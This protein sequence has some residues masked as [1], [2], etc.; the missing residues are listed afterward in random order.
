MKEEWKPIKESCGRYIVSNKGRVASSYN[1]GKCSKDRDDDVPE[2]F[3]L[4]KQK[5]ENTGYCRVSLFIDGKRHMRSVHRLVMEAF[6]G[7]SPKEINH[8]N[9]NKQDNRVTN[10]EYS[11]TKANHI[12]SIARSIERVY[13]DSGKVAAIYSSLIAAKEDG[14]N[15]SNINAVLAGDADIYRGYFWR[16]H[17]EF[18]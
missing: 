8:I 11:T 4:L 13:V 9:E 6:V 10:L 17:D 12:H 2:G 14:Y 7:P 16:Y 15:L 3:Y 5:R 1:Q 18:R